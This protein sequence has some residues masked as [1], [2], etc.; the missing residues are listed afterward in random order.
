MFMVNINTME[1]V[2]ITAYANICKHMQKCITAEEPIFRGRSIKS[3]RL[4]KYLIIKG[5]VQ[6]QFDLKFQKSRTSAGFHIL[7]SYK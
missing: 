5:A 1:A 2:C 4:S 7:E 3:N 6:I